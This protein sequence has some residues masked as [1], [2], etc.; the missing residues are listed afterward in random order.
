MAVT[1]IEIMIAV[2]VRSEIFV[3]IDYTNTPP[4]PK[5]LFHRNKSKQVETSRNTSRKFAE[6]RRDKLSFFI[7]PY[8]PYSVNSSGIIA[9]KYICGI[10]LNEDNQTIIFSTKSVSLAVSSAHAGRKPLF[11]AFLAERIFD[12]AA[13]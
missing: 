12:H 4:F 5:Q 7:L 11:I 1:V 8:F 9:F 6:I 2:T 10:N 3:F 13:Q